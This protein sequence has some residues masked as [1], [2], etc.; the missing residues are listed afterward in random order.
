MK[1]F[2]DDQGRTW[3]ADVRA[4]PGFDHKG[5]YFFFVRPADGD[6]EEGR[7]LRDVRWNSRKSAERTLQTMSDV[8]LRR[9]LR[10]AQG[11]W[12]PPGERAALPSST[13]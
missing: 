2:Q 12:A 9:R 4:R 8:E 5:R 3:V 10:Q 7:A 6:D 1:E 13:G 11:R